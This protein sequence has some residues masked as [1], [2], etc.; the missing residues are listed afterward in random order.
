MN[1]IRGKLVETD[2][3]PARNHFPFAARLQKLCLRRQR[4]G[5]SDSGAGESSGRRIRV[6][7][8]PLF[9]FF[10]LPISTRARGCYSAETPVSDPSARNS[11][12]KF[13]TGKQDDPDYCQCGFHH[14][15]PIG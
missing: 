3:I 10:H 15:P 7:H 8:Q 2:A 1:E 4:R 14:I 9:H 12:L 13:G 5:I 6:T 11:E